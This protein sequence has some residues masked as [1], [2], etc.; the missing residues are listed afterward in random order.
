MDYKEDSKLAKEIRNSNVTSF[1]KTYRKYHKQLYGVAYKYLRSRELA[2]DAIQDIFL[3]LWDL[4]KDIDPSRSLRDFLFTM[5][6][7]HVLNMIRYN[8]RRIIR[9]YKFIEQGNT[10]EE[11]TPADVVYLS[12]CHDIVEEGLQQLPDGKRVIFKMRR[13]EGMS[14]DEVASKL[15]ISVFTVKTQFYHATKFLRDYIKINAEL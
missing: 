9:N 5:L 4:R 8:Q 1:E 10:V 12:E 3:K 11:Q 7:N 2:E 15:G 6:R 14:N 13:Q